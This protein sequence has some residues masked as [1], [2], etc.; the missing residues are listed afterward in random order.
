M[1]TCARPGIARQIHT[2]LGPVLHAAAWARWLLLERAFLDGSATGDLQFAALV[3]RTMCEEIQRLHATDLGADEL[4]DLAGS[5]DV[6]D[7]RRLELFMSIVHASLD[8]FPQ[9]VILDGKDWPLRDLKNVS[10]LDVEHARRDLNNYV[11]PNY[12]SHIAA[13]Y[14]ERT[15]AAR[16]L[17]QALLTVYERFFELSWAETTLSTPTALS[18]VNAIESWPLTVERFKSEVLPHVRQAADDPA[19]KEV[20]KLPAVMGW[21][22]SERPDL[23]EMLEQMEGEP[24]VDDLPRVPFGEPTDGTISKNYKLWEGA[25]AFDVLTFASARSAERNLVREFPSGMPSINDQARWLRFNALALELAMMLD[26]VKARA[27][28]AQLLRQ[29][30]R[31]NSVGIMHCVRSLIEHR[32]LSI[33]LTKEIGGSLTSIAS[34]LRARAPLP[35]SAASIDRNLANVLVLQGKSRL[36]DRQAWVMKEDGGVRTAQLHLRKIVEDAFTKGD[37]FHTFYALGSATI[38]GRATRGYEI[39]LNP[40]ELISRTRILGLLVLERSCDRDEEMDYLAASLRHF[41]L[42]DHAASIGGTS[43]LSTDAMAREAFGQIEGGFVAG[44]HYTGLGTEEC[45]FRFESH[46]QPST[47]ALELLE[48]IGVDITDAWVEAD[49]DPSG[50][51]LI[52]WKVSGRTYWFHAPIRT[53]N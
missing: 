33:W 49:I 42:L 2:I 12:G 20:L 21:L 3:L 25:Q 18:G 36:E 53:S 29:I 44:V 30:T 23:E 32:A 13:I 37:H 10:M 35:K 48:Q 17:L 15:Q 51:I 52:G 14:P 6:E 38:H 47:A 34:K 41:V 40:S 39:A 16:V 8:S 22:A 1:D 31:G 45:P 9:K 4:A 7:R 5:S 26:Q 43:T 11:H 27:L 19:L 28:R 46:I 50:G 24:P